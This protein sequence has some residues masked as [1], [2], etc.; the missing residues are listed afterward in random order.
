[1]SIIGNPT[2]E[3]T[4]LG[5]RSEAAGVMGCIALTAMP[6]NCMTTREK[7]CSILYSTTPII[8]NSTAKN[9]KETQSP[10]RKNVSSIG[11]LRYISNPCHS[12]VPAL[13]IPPDL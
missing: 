2:N 11:V 7:S 10:Q 12:A 6:L 3:D 8:Y 1:M 9:A 4:R 13:V 5:E